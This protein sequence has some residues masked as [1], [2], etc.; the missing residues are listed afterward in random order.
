MKIL[1]IKNN[2]ILLDDDDYEKY[3]NRRI[4]FNNSRGRSFAFVHV[5]GV[6]V[7]LHKLILNELE[8]KVRFKDGNR[9]NLQ[10]DN[11]ESIIFDK[12]KYKKQYHLDNREESVKKAVDWGKNNLEKFKNNQKRFR[13]SNPDKIKDY[14]KNYRSKPEVKKHYNDYYK[15]KAREDH[16]R[17]TNARTRAK[18]KNLEFT[19]PKEKYIDLI[20]KP[21]YY[22]NEKLIEVYGIGLD[23][24]DNNK[25]Y[26]EENVLTCC[27]NCNRTRADRF[28][29][30]ETKVMINALLEYR[31]KK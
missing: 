8:H 27:G 28:T 14:H 2:Q 18:R 25:G 22:C 20:N 5:N 13:E 23:R 10:K 16:Y 21:C 19:I 17:Y 29:V 24:I 26:T 12:V 7:Y 31:K 30:E 6:T 3:K 11:L 9:L 1:V 15:V 4:Y